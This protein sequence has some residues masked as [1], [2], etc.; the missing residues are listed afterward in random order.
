MRLIAAKTLKIA[1][2]T[3]LIISMIM[4]YTFSFSYGTSEGDYGYVNTSMGL[5]VRSGPSTS[6]S[7]KDNIDNN[8]KVNIYEERFVTSSSSSKSNIWIAI[9]SAK[10]SFVRSDF[11]DGVVYDVVKGTT[12]VDLNYRVGAGTGMRKIGTFKKG[13]SID[14]V[15]NALTS[16]GNLW[17]KVKVG[18]SY[19]YVSSKYVTINT[20]SNTEESVDDNNTEEPSDETNVEETT[21]NENIAYVNATFGL[22]VRKGPSTSYSKVG[23]LSNNEKINVYSETFVTSSSYGDKYIWVDISGSKNKYVRSDYLDNYSY[24]SKT[25]TTTTKL[26]YRMGA[27]SSM[28]YAGTFNNGSQVCRRCEE[29]ANDTSCRR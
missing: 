20:N 24:N 6:Y 17:Y 21:G 15:C 3:V 1:L 13:Q 29:R 4:T 22:N 12:T 9:N 5:N 19:Y 28:K 10:T 25:G 14:I 16:S 7:V 2:T 26:N 11:I 18:S 8:T 23:R 27:G